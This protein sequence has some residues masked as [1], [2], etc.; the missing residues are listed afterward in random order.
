MNKKILNM[1]KKAYSFF[2]R[3]EEELGE[4]ESLFIEAEFRGNSEL[5]F[6]YKKYKGIKD[7][8]QISDVRYLLEEMQDNLDKIW[9]LAYKK[10]KVNHVYA[11]PKD[12]YKRI[13]KRYIDL[14]KQK[15]IFYF[16]ERAAKFKCVHNSK[17]SNPYV[18]AIGCLEKMYA[19][20]N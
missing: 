16:T 19:W 14:P 1:I 18:L 15:L 3:I 7:K 9:N 2:D 12:L 11:L 10:Y 6:Y 13:C 17:D 8:V 20:S 5:K 4:I